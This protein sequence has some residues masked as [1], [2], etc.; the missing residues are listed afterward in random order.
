MKWQSLNTNPN[1]NKRKV[2]TC[3]LFS[4]SNI[5][6][7]RRRRICQILHEEVS[8]FMGILFDNDIKK[9]ML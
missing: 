2:A 1:A 3:G 5:A 7:F 8:G 4:F 6:C 9:E